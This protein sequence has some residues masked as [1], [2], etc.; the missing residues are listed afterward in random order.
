MN[1][2]EILNK[3]FEKAKIGG[4]KLE[5]VDDYLKE[6]SDEFAQLQKTNS[7]LEEKA[8]AA[9][10]DTFIIKPL[11]QSTL[12]YNLQKLIQDNAAGPEG[13]DVRKLPFCGGHILVAED[14]DLNW[15]I[16]NELFSDAGLKPDRAEN[17]KVCV[18]LFSASEKGYYCASADAFADDVQKCLK[19]GMNAHTPK[20]IDVDRVVM[21]IKMY[22]EENAALSK[23]NPADYR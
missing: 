23:K 7:E 13:A 15:E 8:K 12:Y 17:G 20:P 4:Y 5:E 6:V 22:M 3:Q 16:A 9:G 1:A 2:K 18:D 11:F 10:I 14:N 21:L 19:C